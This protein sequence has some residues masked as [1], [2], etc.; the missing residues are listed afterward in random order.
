VPTAL[1]FLGRLPVARAAV[2][3]ARA[4]HEGQRRLGDGAPFLLHPLEV[5]SL[6]QRSGYPDEVI[7]AAVLHDV[8]EDTDVD[9][10]ELER[11][12]GPKVAALVAAVSD[13]PSI[14]DE[15][16][17]KRELTERVRRIGGHAAAV[18]AADKISKVREL[19]VRLAT[20]DDWAA[21]EPLI[22]RH[23]RSLAMLDETLPGSR[24]TEVLR[25]ELETLEKLPPG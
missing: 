8:L 22:A 10:D 24:L 4:N 1:S 14:V 15:D 20:G 11:R 12:F 19:R 21:I 2:E 6:L 18:Y 13:D 7:A 5:A 3:F 23:R 9:R 25:F 16:E 17:R